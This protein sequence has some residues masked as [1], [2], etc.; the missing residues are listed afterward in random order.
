MFFSRIS[1]SED[2]GNIRELYLS[3]FPEQERILFGVL[4]AT[5]AG[6]G[7]LISYPYYIKFEL[8]KL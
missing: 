6:A 1:L 3:A 8:T 2:Y 7:D 4:T 5:A